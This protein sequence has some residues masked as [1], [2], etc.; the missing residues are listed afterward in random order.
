[1][2]RHLKVNFLIPCNALDH[3]QRSECAEKLLLKRNGYRPALCN[4]RDKSL[5]LRRMTLTLG[6]ET[7]F[8]WFLTGDYQPF[9]N[10]NQSDQPSRRHYN[11][12]LSTLLTAIQHVATTR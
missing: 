3:L 5:K 10:N 8:L 11:T 7:L 4:G 2:N 1:M 12:F 6:F 9:E